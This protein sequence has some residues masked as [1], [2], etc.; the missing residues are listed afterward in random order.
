MI[1]YSQMI[2]SDADKSKFE[3][4]YH[5]YKGL[6]FHIA[7]KYLK[8]QQDAEDA[9]HH[10]FVKIAENIS[11]ISDPLSPKTKQYIVTIIENRSID[12]LRV[13]RKTN[14]L[15]FEE[16]RNHVLDVPDVDDQLAKCILKL[17]EKQRQVLWLKYHFGYDLHEISEMLGISLSWAQKIDQRGKKKLE[18]FLKEDGFVL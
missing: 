5:E 9:V 11:K 16:D 8:H 15:P 12:V 7:Y 10:A 6:M 3:I 14:V 18:Q 17:S 4:I 2:G 13:E 1:I